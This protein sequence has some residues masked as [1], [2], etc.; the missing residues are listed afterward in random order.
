M[1]FRIFNN[2]YLDLNVLANASVSSAQAAFPVTNAYNGNRRSKVWRSNGFFRI[3]N[4]NNSFVFQEVAG[5]DLLA[6]IPADDYN[7]ALDL[8]AAIKAA[9]ELV[10]ANTYTIKNDET[11]N[12]KFSFSSNGGFFTI[13]SSSASFTCGDVLGIDS[14]DLTGAT[15]Y[16]ADLL[17]ITT[18][19]W[20]LWDMGISSNPTC[21]ALIGPRNNPLKI[22]KTA[23]L[24]IQ[25]NETNAWDS[26]SFE[27]SL[28]YDEEVITVV[29][30]N[31]IAPEAYRY[32]RLLIVDQ[33]INGFV[34]IGALYLGTHYKVIRGGTVL[35]LRNTSVDRSETIYSEGG[36]EFSDVKQKTASFSLQFSG[37]SSEEVERLE[38]FFKK[39]GMS[40]PFFVSLD[41][42][43]QFS[44]TIN[45]KIRY[46]KF[47]S[48]LDITNTSNKFFNCNMNFTE[49][50]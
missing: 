31:G 48:S 30:E 6:T 34:E 46:V 43:L 28:P 35:P 18:G 16:L 49:Q 10:G 26:P 1:E 44:S 21:F 45:R 40:I 4:S 33:N 29:T 2:N 50:L 11:T 39:V 9:L 3:T 22:S 37:V 15:T 7:S 27:M 24:K 12:S 42:D 8:C 13:R 20:F 25:A 17:R 47:S 32:W 14:V 23:I 38:D 5:V 19:E 41:D 36:Q